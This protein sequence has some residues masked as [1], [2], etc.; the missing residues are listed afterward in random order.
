MIRALSQM[1]VDLSMKLEQLNF[2][3]EIL[4]SEKLKLVACNMGWRCDFRQ[5]LAALTQM[6][7]GGAACLL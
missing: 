2:T 3:E 5:S 6:G 7:D 4:L 1:F